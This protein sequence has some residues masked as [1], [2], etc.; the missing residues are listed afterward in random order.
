MILGSMPGEES[1]RKRE[2]YANPRNSFWFILGN[3][4]GFEPD[5]GYEERK[6]ILKKKNIALWDVLKACERKGSLDSSIIDATSVEND[7]LAFYAEFPA[8]KYVFFNGTKAEAEYKKRIL[9]AV[10][11]ERPALVY[12]KLPSTSP[13]MAGL[14]KEQKLARWSVILEKII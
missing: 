2:Y 3:I 7:L 9:P 12:K 8:I 13:A 10:R 11:R 1:L 6:K 4:L 14:T 5:A